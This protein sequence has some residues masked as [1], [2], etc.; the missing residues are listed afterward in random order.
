[1]SDPT[2]YGQPDHTASELYDF[3]PDYLDNGG[4]HT[5][6][7][8]PNK[9]AYLVVDGTVGEPGGAFNGSAFPG[10]GADKAAVLYWTALRTLTPAADF[11]DLGAVLRQ[12]CLN[13]AA[14]AAAGITATDCQS[15]DGAVAAT[16]LTRWAGPTEPR[17]VTLKPGIRSVILRWSAP[18]S[19][20]S[21]PINSYAIHISPAVD[22]V[23]FV[24]VEPS[25]RSASARGSAGRGRLHL[26]AGRGHGRRHVAP[27]APRRRRV[28][29]ARGLAGQRDLRLGA[30]RAGCSHRRR[31][32]AGRRPDG[33]PDAPRR[34]V[35]AVGA[36][37]RRHDRPRAAAS[38]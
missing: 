7:G 37:G 9:A 3:A 29:A 11:T 14:A 25:A 10:I 28:G 23:D 31:A 2:L 16:G 32:G 35:R 19:A 4:V 13:L 12:S 33:P 24:P 8:V 5:N 6:S 27:G 21:S 17:D 34:P 38:S 18:E 30:A 1:M 22:Q 26:P 15:V 36:G 20:G